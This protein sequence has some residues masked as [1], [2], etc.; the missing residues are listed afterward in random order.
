MI[1]EQSVQPHIGP[2]RNSQEESCGQCPD[3][4]LEEGGGKPGISIPH[5]SGFHERGIERTSACRVHAPVQ[6]NGC[7]P[8]RRQRAFRRRARDPSAIR[9]GWGAIESRETNPCGRQPGAFRSRAPGS[10]CLT[11][12]DCLLLNVSIARVRKHDILSPA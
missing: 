11:D 12:R 2:C 5:P 3:C 1:V 10:S 6:S 9:E 7:N 8:S 4:R